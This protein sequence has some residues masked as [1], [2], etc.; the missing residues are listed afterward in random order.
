MRP[1][2]S[3]AK[4]ASALVSRTARSDG[5]RRQVAGDPVLTLFR[6]VAGSSHNVSIPHSTNGRPRDSTMDSG[7]L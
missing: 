5:V 6:G 4:M 3:A 1:R 7:D 2:P